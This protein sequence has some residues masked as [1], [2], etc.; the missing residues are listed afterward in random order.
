MATHSGARGALFSGLI[1]YAG[2]FP[3]TALALPEAVTNYRAYLDCP[4]RW[5]LARFIATTAHLLEIGDDLLSRFSPDVTLEISLVSKDLDW[6]IPKVIE[7]QNRSRGRLKVT[8]LEAPLAPGVAVSEQLVKIQQARAALDTSAEPA[9]VFFELPFCEDWDGRLPEA[10]DAIHAARCNGAPFCFKLRCGGL[11]PHLVPTPD[12]IAAAICGCRK[13]DIPIKFTA[14]LHH[15]FRHEVTS[16]PQ[17]MPPM[18]GY[19]NVFFG[20]IAAHALGLSD[21][22]LSPIITEMTR[23]DPAIAEDGI[24]WLGHTVSTS[25]IQR[26][27]ERFSISYGSCSFVEPI[28]DAKRLGWL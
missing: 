5:I 10:L 27:R 23:I 4:E 6:E 1:D 25:E 28:E 26:A 16:S 9:P 20:A 2:L 15:P 11:E 14:G 3:P 8:A 7:Q 18:H 22:D 21:G 12:R 17:P 19:F 13:L 24:S